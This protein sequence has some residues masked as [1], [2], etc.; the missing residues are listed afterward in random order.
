MGIARVARTWLLS[1]ADPTKAGISPLN[2]SSGEAATKVREA[3]RRGATD[4][5]LAAAST[6]GAMFG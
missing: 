6:A 5:R 3:A 2:R 1:P 4:R